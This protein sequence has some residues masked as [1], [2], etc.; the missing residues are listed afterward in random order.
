M[1]FKEPQQTLVFG[2]SGQ[3]AQALKSLWPHQVPFLSKAEAD[4][5]NLPQL[6]EIL[7]QRRPKFV[8][9]T[10]AYTAVDKAEEDEEKSQCFRINAEAPGEIAKWCAQNQAILIFF[11]TDYVYSPD[12]AQAHHLE[13]EELRPLNAYGQSKFQ[14]EQLIRDAGCRHLI[15]RVSWLYSNVGKNFFLTIKKLAQEKETLSVVADQI[16]YPTAVPDLALAIAR[17][18]ERIQDPKFSAWGVYN[19]VGPDSVSWQGFAEAIVQNLKE[20][21]AAV[22][23]Q[24][25]LPITSADWKALY[26]RTTERP[27]NSRMSN[28]KFKNEFGFELPPWEEALKSLVRTLSS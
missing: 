5:S 25:V 16:G 22:K 17:V 2:S 23:T 26:P 10:A 18:L 12:Q 19:L 7:D 3:L 21:S 9:V 8:V 13:S 6:V 14:G 20:I 27:L 1:R 4:F 15:F 28:S 24:S 11:S